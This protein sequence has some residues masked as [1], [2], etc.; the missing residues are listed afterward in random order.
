M[1]TKTPEEN[2]L[3]VQG[4]K[5]NVA[6]APTNRD[7]VVNT[8]IE[9]LDEVPSGVMQIPYCSL[10]HPT[11]QEPGKAR[12][13]QFLLRDTEEVVD[14][15][16][17]GILR[18]KRMENTKDNETW[19]DLKI[20]AVRFPNLNPVILPVSVGSWSNVGKL[21]AKLKEKKAGKAWEYKVEVSS[22]QTKNKD[23]QPYYEH[24]FEVKEK[25][26]EGAMVFLDEIYSH[27]A[28][29]LDRE[30]APAQ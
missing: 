19:V 21:I 3:E 30:Q 5:E 10:V 16:E 25:M 17:I 8:G 28:N 2:S 11:T 4:T 6:L 14:K 15:L 12:P 29:S 24:V 13:G 9:G 7:G 1:A 26:D 23:N 27:Y 18:M 22:R 20:L